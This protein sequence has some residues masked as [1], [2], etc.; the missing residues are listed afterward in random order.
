MFLPFQLCNLTLSCHY[1]VI[2][3]H[4]KY[5]A[6]KR[7]HT[8]TACGLAFMEVRTLRQHE[9]LHLGLPAAAEGT[10][11]TAACHVCGKMLLKGNLKAHIRSRHRE[12]GAEGTGGAALVA[13]YAEQFSCLLCGHATKTSWLKVRK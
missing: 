12:E 4:Y 11:R 10:T 13:S 7:E 5:H 3:L 8:C 6:G 9:R 1:D 2:K